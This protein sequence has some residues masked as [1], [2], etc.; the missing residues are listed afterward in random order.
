MHVEDAL[1]LLSDMQ[2]FVPDK[3]LEDLLHLLPDT[4]SELNEDE[5]DCVSA[6]V[7]EQK[8]CLPHKQE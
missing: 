8:R 5:L 2:G 4:V 1:K 3:A 6:A 7:M